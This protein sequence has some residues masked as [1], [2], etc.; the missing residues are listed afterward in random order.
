M[1]EGDLIVPFFV[2]TFKIAIFELFKCQGRQSFNFKILKN[3]F[4]KH[5]NATAP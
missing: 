3:E 2:S 4:S 1:K 5:L